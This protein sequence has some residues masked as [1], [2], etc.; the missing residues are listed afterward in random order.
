MCSERGRRSH[1]MCQ[2][3]RPRVKVTCS[4]HTHRV[5][6]YHPP[7]THLGLQLCACW[8][9]PPRPPWPLESIDVQGRVSTMCSEETEAYLTYKAPKLSLTALW[10]SHVN[11]PPPPA[12]H[13]VSALHPLLVQFQ[14]ARSAACAVRR[15]GTHSSCHPSTKSLRRKKQAS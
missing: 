3:R 14:C 1:S 11:V 12:L 7:C 5:G 15:T 8:Y 2:Q 4:L 10:T 9:P 6:R 13:F